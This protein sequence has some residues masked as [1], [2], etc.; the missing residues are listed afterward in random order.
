MSKEKIIIANWKMNLSYQESLKYLKSISRFLIGL[1]NAII[2]LCPSFVSLADIA[3]EIRG[4]KIELGAQDVFWLEEGAYTGEIS[5]RSLK[6]IGCKYVIIGHSERRKYINETDQ[7]VNQKIKITLK[8]YITPILCIGENEEQRKENQTAK[9]LKD[10]LTEDLKQVDPAN[11]KIIIAY[12]P[13]WA[14]GTGHEATAEQVN[15]AVLIIKSCLA[16][17]FKNIDID[18]HFKILYG[19]SVNQEDIK[20]FLNLDSIDGFLIGSAS[21]DKRQF[22]GII[23]RLK[24]F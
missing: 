18:G 14:V 5:I 7:M 2:I 17:L 16:K 4:R 10:Q 15:E 19:G 12:E 22:L 8:H 11:R 6:E 24:N 1:K 20:E 23:N 9:V 3:K 13:V 21:A